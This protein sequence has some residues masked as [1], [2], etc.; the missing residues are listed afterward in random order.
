MYALQNLSFISEQSA[1][2]GLLCVSRAILAQVQQTNISKRSAMDWQ[3]HYR[4]S[5]RYLAAS[6]NF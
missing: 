6:P 5:N 1:D 3:E 4:L 2:R